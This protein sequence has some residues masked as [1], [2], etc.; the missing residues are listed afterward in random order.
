MKQE[1][2]IPLRDNL[3]LSIRIPPLTTAAREVDWHY[4]EDVEMLLI[5]S[6]SFSLF[7]NNQAYTLFAGDILF[8]DSLVPHKTYTPVGSQRLLLQFK[9]TLFA[10]EQAKLLP[11]LPLFP[12]HSDFVIFKSGTPENERLLPCLRALFRE[13]AEQGKS[14]NA[15]IKAAF[16]EILAILYRLDVLGDPEEISVLP[17]F[18]RFLPILSY[19]YEH[20]AEPVSLADISSRLNLDRSYFCRLFKKTMHMSF[21]EYVYLLRLGKAEELLFESNQSVTEIALECGFSS[22]AYFTKVFK[23]KT[24]YTPSFYKQLKKR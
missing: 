20:I 23:E 18:E 21:M 10:G 13:Y 2:I 16:Y 17:A 24:G 5:E 4:H 11:L 14:H 1:F 22:P 3:P 9:H 15:F 7:I 8:V 6:G 12:S 19:V